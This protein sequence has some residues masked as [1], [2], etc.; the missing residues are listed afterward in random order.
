[1][2][3]LPVDASLVSTAHHTVLFSVPAANAAAVL[4]S[5]CSSE[6]CSIAILKTSDWGDMSLLVC[7][8]TNRVSV[9]RQ[10]A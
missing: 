7:E 9:A 2:A 3:I 8:M 6:K 5:S 1:M 10:L 4:T